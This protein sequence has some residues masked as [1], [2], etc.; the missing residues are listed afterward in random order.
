MFYVKCLMRWFA[1]LSATCIENVSIR[2]SFTLLPLR[3]KLQSSK[4]TTK[5]KH[6]NL[7]SLSSALKHSAWELSFRKKTSALRLS[8]AFNSLRA[9]TAPPDL[10][11][12]TF[13]FLSF[14][15]CFCAFFSLIPWSAFKLD[16]LA[17]AHLVS[18]R[19]GKNVKFVK[20]SAR[21]KALKR[22]NQVIK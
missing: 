12:L 17:R 6:K 14:F 21:C 11:P 13:Y 16:R 22:V 1:E 5:M 19:G 9:S 3:Q 2:S 4:R 15:S 18:I 10:A 7:F 20:S 8:R